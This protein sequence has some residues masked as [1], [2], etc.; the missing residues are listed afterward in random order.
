M[1]LEL[2]N[3]CMVVLLCTHVPDIIF[4]SVITKRLS[5][6]YLYG[7]LAYFIL[8]QEK[9]YQPVKFLTLILRVR[10]HIEPVRMRLY[11]NDMVMRFLSRIRR[12][13]KVA[14]DFCT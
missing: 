2:D 1:Y 6:G 9:S 11:A 10:F 3:G 13:E 12:L 14:I 4:F 8:I 7:T 5:V